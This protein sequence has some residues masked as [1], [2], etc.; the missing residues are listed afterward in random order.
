MNLF[1]ESDESEEEKEP[2]SKYQYPKYIIILDDLSNEL[3]NRSVDYL[4][5][6]NRHFQ[7]K[8]I[9][10]TQYPND[11]TPST[12]K[13]MDFIL[14]FKGLPLDKINK[15]HKE[16][17]LAIDLDTFEK[18]YHHATVKPYSFLYIDVRNERLRKN[19]NIEYR[20]KET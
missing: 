4:C 2:K 14:I 16:A 1:E 18:I 12:W 19:F 5:K 10:S 15:I 9:I 13:Q 11:L 3:K 20:L 7:A 8:V 17:D 6:R